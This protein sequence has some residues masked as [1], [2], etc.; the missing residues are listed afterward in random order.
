MEHPVNWM[1][2]VLMA[3]DK[4]IWPATLICVLLILREPLRLLLPFAQSIKF[5]EFEVNFSQELDNATVQ[6]SAA[7]PKY[8]PP[9]HLNKND[10]LKL[11]ADFLP[12]QSIL[13]A[14]KSVETSAEALLINQQPQLSIPEKQR[15]KFMGEHLLKLQL[16][17]QKQGNLFHELRQLRN[18][19]AHAK[20]YSVNSV[21]AV[22]YI[23]L[24][25]ALVEYLDQAHQDRH[26]AKAS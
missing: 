23:E 20:N 13:Q 19:V 11:N 25:L 10:R 8:N 14:W 7:L 1:D 18:K 21:L 4:L 26:Q 16:I 9:V 15:Y 24:C 3:M 6:A 12:N 5:K 17:T 2:F 22:Q